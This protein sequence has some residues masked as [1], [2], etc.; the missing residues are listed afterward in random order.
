MQQQGYQQLSDDANEVLNNTLNA[1]DANAVKEEQVVTNMLLRLKDNYQQT[2]DEIGQTLD[3]RNQAIANNQAMTLTTMSQTTADAV[4]IMATD[5]TTAVDAMGANTTMT[6]DAVYASSQEGATM[7]AD[8][9]DLILDDV[10]GNNEIAYSA[11][12]G[13]I[14]S[15]GTVVNETTMQAIEDINTS[16]DG[17][18][19]GA[20]ISETAILGHVNNINTAVN[21]MLTNTRTTL[22]TLGTE[23]AAKFSGIADSI[24]KAINA[25][26]IDLGY[27]DANKKGTVANTEKVVKANNTPQQIQ[28]KK[29]EVKAAAATSAPAK[30]TSSSATTAAKATTNN[31]AKAK[32]KG[33]SFVVKPTKTSYTYTGKAIKPGVTVTANGKTVPSGSYTATYTNNIKVGTATI[34]VTGKGNYAGWTG[35]CTFT[36]TA[37]KK[38]SSGGDGKAKVGD[39]VTFATGVYH[40]DSWGNG[41]SGYQY[42]GKKVYITSINSGSPYPYHISTGKKLGSGDLG[43]LKL[44]QLKGY[45]IGTLGTKSDE[46]NWTHQGEIIRRSDGAI[47]RQLPAGTQVLPQDLSENLMKWGA[48]DPS[49]LFTTSAPQNLTSNSSQVTTNYYDSLIHIDGNVDDSM[50]S[51]I[52]ELANALLAN[53]NFKQGSIKN[54]TTE[55]SREYRKTGH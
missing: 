42:R 8:A 25:A 23:I 10:V 1:I 3:A 35:S 27:G 40:E 11:I 6:M 29:A 36:I 28:Q 50:L 15:T 12:Q 7:N 19:T 48:I 5:M 16:V 26:K 4:N 17:I 14:D 55:L 20:G 45:K 22:G 52:D 31:N 43:W 39:Q 46:F 37:A 54:I 21:G 38:K 13:L 9:L 2:Y 30:V 24:T 47:L 53:R 44:S 41:N 33:G 18:L 32:N 51:R 49:K 34:K